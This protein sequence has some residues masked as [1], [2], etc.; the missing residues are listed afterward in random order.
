[1]KVVAFV[2]VTGPTYWVGRFVIATPAFEI[3]YIPTL[4]F[5]GIPCGLAVTTVIVDTD[6][7]NVAPDVITAESGVRW[8]KFGELTNTLYLALFVKVD[9]VLDPTT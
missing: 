6:L 4:L 3:P 5:A 8:I 7:E 9:N 1:V 2:T